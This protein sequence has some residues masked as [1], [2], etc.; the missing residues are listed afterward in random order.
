MFPVKLGELGESCGWQEPT[1]EQA[2]TTHAGGSPTDIAMHDAGTNREA[3]NY[4]AERQKAATSSD[5]HITPMDGSGSAGGTG[6]DMTKF[7]GVHDFFAELGKGIDIGLA[8][9]GEAPTTMAGKHSP[10]AAMLG[11]WDILD[12]QNFDDY[13]NFLARMGFPWFLRQFL[14]RAQ[15]GLSVL[16]QGPNHVV[17]GM[18]GKFHGVQ[19]EN[20][21]K[22]LPPMVCSHTH[23]LP[24]VL[25]G[26]VWRLVDRPPDPVPTVHPKLCHRF[27]NL[28]TSTVSA[29]DGLCTCTCEMLNYNPRQFYGEVKSIR[30]V[31]SYGVVRGSI[32]RESTPFLLTPV[33]FTPF[34]LA[35]FLLAPFLLTPFL[36]TPFLLTPFLPTPFPLFLLDR[37]LTSRRC[38]AG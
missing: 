1:E 8:K 34:L 14:V 17:I 6:K 12:K 26:K 24:T 10:L 2:A 20:I 38:G 30:Q 13:S 23:H 33:H 15:S 22:N 25:A 36:L 3:L 9:V 27:E 4:W 35:P 5:L 37:C 16:E 32:A 21:I 31:R 11:R 28:H 29:R 18:C 7:R 19:L